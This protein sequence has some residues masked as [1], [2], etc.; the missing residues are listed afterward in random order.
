VLLMSVARG[1]EGTITLSIIRT[2]DARQGTS[3]LQNLRPF[4]RE[5]RAFSLTSPRRKHSDCRGGHDCSGKPSKDGKCFIN[6]N[7]LI[8]FFREAISMIMAM[9]GTAATPLIIALQINGLHWVERSEVKSRS[10]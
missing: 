9:I 7:S 10:H 1:S 3:P 8:T 6:A 5:W 4:L 2:A